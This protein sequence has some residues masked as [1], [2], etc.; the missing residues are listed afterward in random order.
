MAKSMMTIRVN[1][2]LDK[3]MQTLRDSVFGSVHEIFQGIAADAVRMTPVDTGAAVTSFSFK[4]N[5]SSGRSRTSRGKPRRQN[6][7]AMKKIGYDQLMADL[8][9]IDFRSV[10]SV[11]LS[12]GAPHWTYFNN[13]NRVQRE[14]NGRWIFEQLAATYRNKSYGASD[15]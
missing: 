3:K 2:S 5:R 11:T 10:K 9:A 14:P 12:N 4:A 15:S 1:P 13:N 6:V 8:A 7:T